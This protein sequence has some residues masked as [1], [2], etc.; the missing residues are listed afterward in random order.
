M[1]RHHFHKRPMLFLRMRC[2]MEILLL[3]F[4]CNLACVIFTAAAAIHQRDRHPV[5]EEN[6]NKQHKGT[7]IQIDH[8]TLPVLGIHKIALGVFKK[9]E[10]HPDEAIKFLMDWSGL[11]FTR[12]GR[13]KEHQDESILVAPEGGV[14]T[15]EEDGDDDHE[16]TAALFLDLVIVKVPDKCLRVLE[17]EESSS[18]EA[19]AASARGGRAVLD[20]VR[21]SSSSNC[22][23]WSTTL[24]IG[25]PDRSN[26][27]TMQYC[28]TPQAARD[29]GACTDQ[30]I[31]HVLLNNADIADAADQSRRRH[32]VISFS[33]R[34]NDIMDPDMISTTFIGR[35]EL[36][37]IPIFERRRKDTGELIADDDETSTTTPSSSFQIRNTRKSHVY[38]HEPGTYVA[39]FANCHH[40]NQNVN[41]HGNIIWQ[42]QPDKE[43]ALL[44]KVSAFHISIAMGYC[45]LLVWFYNILYGAT[46]STTSTRKAYYCTLKTAT[47]T[48]MMKT[49]PTL[50]PPHTATTARHEWILLV[51][52]VGLAEALLRA[53]QYHVWAYNG[54]NRNLGGMALLARL[55][56]AAKQSIGRHVMLWI[57][58][59]GDEGG[60]TTTP[61]SNSGSP[62]AWPRIQLWFII[63][64]STAFFFASASYDLLLWLSEH[65][66][67]HKRAAFHFMSTVVSCQF[68][69][70]CI[71]LIA[72][73]AAFCVTIRHLKMLSQRENTKQQHHQLLQ[74]YRLV[75]AVVVCG[76]LWTLLTFAWYLFTTV[77]DTEMDV[78]ESNQMDFF[79]M[80]T[81]VA[82]VCRPST[83]KDHQQ[84]RHQRASRDV[85]YMTTP[86][87]SEQLRRRAN[88]SID[89]E[90]GGMN[91]MKLNESSPSLSF[92]KK[93]YD[94]FDIIDPYWQNDDE[95]ALP[96]LKSSSY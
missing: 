66:P 54:G 67:E 94:D 65:Y 86:T 2:V 20:D 89:E 25:A 60:T 21:S 42:V 78:H 38:I 96:L 15:E 24:G 84:Q 76:A 32:R 46:T 83:P 72:I 35:N 87:K 90:H 8:A 44:S 52:A 18:A 40:Q 51:I 33:S 62:Y 3:L 1:Y 11:E 56:G 53:V 13:H 95:D 74:Q 41:I 50:S 63:S 16:E 61:N 30:D 57:A 23:D 49:P 37:G 80:L 55:M 81:L 45:T 71:Y 7:I 43:V 10:H 26:E 6:E 82:V 39:I 85:A 70:H 92:S 27:P 91:M 31:G 9:E 34:I 4:L 73:P 68:A 36:N 29:D 22:D 48:V 88:C 75:L 69:L 59:G 64:L 17:D 28:C 5:E 77:A 58:L 12:I 14:L 79:V 47:K 93:W 19:P